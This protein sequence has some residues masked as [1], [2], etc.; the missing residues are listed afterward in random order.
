VSYVDPEYRI[1]TQAGAV[2]AFSL[3]Y[4]IGFSHILTLF[5]QHQDG[6]WQYAQWRDDGWENAVFWWFL[7]VVLT[8]A[9]PVVMV[10]SA[11]VG[12][13]EKWGKRL[14]EKTWLGHMVAAALAIILGVAAAIVVLLWIWALEFLLP[15]VWVL[16]ITVSA[17][18]RLVG[19]M[20]LAGLKRGSKWSVRGGLL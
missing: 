18:S 5:R 14:V 15:P 10:F 11:I 12:W 17:L 1:F 3:S 20:T 2:I 13:Y 7:V 16:A 4:C 8:A 19:R 6:S 9:L